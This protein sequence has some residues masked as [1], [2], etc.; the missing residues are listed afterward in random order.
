MSISDGLEPYFLC[1]KMDKTRSM[2]EEMDGDVYIS[3][4]SRQ[5]TVIDNMIK[6][7][8]QYSSLFVPWFG[9]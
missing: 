5:F 3:R 1:R 8:W 2:K 7:Q 4:Q 6:V 9:V